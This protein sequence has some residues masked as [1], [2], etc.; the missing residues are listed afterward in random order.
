VDVDRDTVGIV[1]AGVFAGLAT[2][3]AVVAL[4]RQPFLLVLAVPFGVAAYLVWMGATGRTPFGGYRRVTPEEARQARARRAERETGGRSR[5]AEEARRQAAGQRARGGERTRAGAERGR[6]RPQS[7]P[8]TL[9]RRE[10]ARILGVDADAEP[11]VVRSAYREQVKEVHPDTEGG[12][13]ERFRKVNEA[14]ERL[15]EE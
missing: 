11:A 5:F 12:D 4:A 9:A 6:R 3:L 7:E 10:A 14:Y 15:Q 8:D 2:V 1:L 13:E